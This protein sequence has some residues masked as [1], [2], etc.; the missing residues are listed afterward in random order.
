MG[1][2]SILGGREL[3]IAWIVS[4][5]APDTANGVTKLGRPQLADLIIKASRWFGHRPGFNFRKVRIIF[6]ARL[7]AIEGME[8]ATGLYE[9]HSD[10]MH[11]NSMPFAWGMG[12]D[13]DG[14]KMTELHDMVKSS[15]KYDCMIFAYLTNHQEG[16]NYGCTIEGF[17]SGFEMKPKIKLPARASG[18]LV[19][20]DTDA[21]TVMCEKPFWPEE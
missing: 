10:Y 3:K 7:Y 18:F 1:S 12:S 5:R 2:N 15:S 16:S 19:K 8:M 21:Q 14:A 11:I 9:H 17:L 20:I 13:G 4:P 6:D